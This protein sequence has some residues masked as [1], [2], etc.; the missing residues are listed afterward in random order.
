M[1]YTMIGYRHGLRQPSIEITF[2]FDEVANPNFVTL[3]EFIDNV[4][5]TTRI[6]FEDKEAFEDTAFRYLNTLL[7][8]N[9]YLQI[10]GHIPCFEPGK[11]I[12]L[13]KSQNGKRY[14]SRIV[15]PYCDN[16]SSQ[17]I[18]LSLTFAEK[19]TKV[20]AQT[21]PERIN[22]PEIYKSIEEMI[23]YPLRRLSKSGV[24]TLPILQAC[25]AINAPFRH[26]GDGI[27]QLGWG[28][29]RQILSRS[30]LDGD[31]AIGA[32]ISTRKD[33]TACLLQHAG[34]PTT[35]HSLAQTL[36]DA[37]VTAKKLGFP[38]VIK[39]TDRER[40]EG[41]T[42]QIVDSTAIEPAWIYAKKFSDNILV[43]KQVVGTCYRL[44]VA[45]QKFLY[46]VE[47]LPRSITG[48]GAR[49]IR[50]LYESDKMQND[51][52]PPW[53]RKK[54]IPLNESL[55]KTIKFQNFELDDIPED[56][57]VINLLPIESTE[58]GE[59]TTDVTG[60]V[61]PT[62]I[63][64]AERAAKTLCLKN[65]GID[66]ITTNITLPWWETNAVINE[67]NF[68]PHFGGTLAA[69]SRMPDFLRSLLP[70]RGRIPVEVYI[71]NS[72]AIYA[73]RERMQDLIISGLSCFLC[74][75]ES[76]WCPSGEITMATSNSTAYS[77]CQAILMNPDVEVLILAI[78]TDEFLTTGLPVDRIDQLT[79]V[80]QSL[81][82][83]QHTGQH[84][85][86]ARATELINLL[87]VYQESAQET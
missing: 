40:S 81:L 25:S 80:N 61:S 58:W 19:L 84:I 71:G 59:Q 74:N 49:S 6:S 79:I 26:L 57:Q 38:V 8:I 29:R 47:R 78:Q 1:E 14:R 46:A 15:I 17:Y 37:I 52:L 20:I 36:D 35:T 60:L 72:D 4:F 70:N 27:Y 45:N 54:N 76:A 82:S 66:I 41:V 55:T 28:A 48:D 75:H 42:T 24:S 13:K 62:Y 63:E 16:I 2:E 32:E 86:E 23:V 67:V 10:I 7:R 22:Y 69:R 33:K 77:I 73:A 44:M 39:P 30:A 51:S 85:S 56:R 68:R 11:I 64:L 21:S 50:E 18:K 53:S 3:N 12:R 65:A 34:L 9:A 87:S 31:S 43:E 83:L 5:K